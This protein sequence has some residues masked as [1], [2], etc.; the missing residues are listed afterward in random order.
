MHFRGDRIAFSD[1]TADN[2]F[3]KRIFYQVLDIF[4]DKAGALFRIETLLG[5]EFDDGWGGF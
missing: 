1:M 2:L 5:D 4:T 3:C